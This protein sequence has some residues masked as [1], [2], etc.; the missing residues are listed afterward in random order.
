MMLD[1]GRNVLVMRMS[2]L[3]GRI[4]GMSLGIIPIKFFVIPK[5]GIAVMPDE[6]FRCEIKGL[7]DF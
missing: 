2:R 1:I 6:G 4:V 5:N 7:G 3:Q